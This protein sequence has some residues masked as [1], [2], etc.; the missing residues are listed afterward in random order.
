M[1]GLVSSTCIQLQLHEKVCFKKGLFQ[2]N[3]QKMSI[4]FMLWLTA[5]QISLFQSKV[6][7]H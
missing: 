1:A 5:D 2:S 6:M 7:I 3:I 4:F